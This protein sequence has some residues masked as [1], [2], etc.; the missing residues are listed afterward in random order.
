MPFP[1]HPDAQARWNMLT[2]VVASQA[3]QSSTATSPSGRR[4][5][6]SSAA[7]AGSQAKPAGR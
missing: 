1:M 7:S 4:G 3:T 2:H 5:E 6:V